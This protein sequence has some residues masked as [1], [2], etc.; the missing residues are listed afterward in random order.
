M[1]KDSVLI[2]LQFYHKKL[3][4]KKETA[5]RKNSDTTEKNSNNTYLKSSY[6]FTTQ[7]F[8]YFS[9]SLLRIV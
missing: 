4:E 3:L 9:F 2:L 5:G 8:L 7:N 6:P 1:F